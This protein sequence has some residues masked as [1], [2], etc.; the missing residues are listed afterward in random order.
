MLI[1]YMKVQKLL[2]IEAGIIGVMTILAI[3]NTRLELF[4]L[5]GLIGELLTGLSC[6]FLPGHISA[7]LMTNAADPP[8]LW[9]V[10]AGYLI[11]GLL[12]FII[13]KRLTVL[14]IK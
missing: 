6:L 11:Q 4:K 1:E 9:G 12:I 13:T 5:E 2:F 10:I 7:I 8:R 14:V 3:F